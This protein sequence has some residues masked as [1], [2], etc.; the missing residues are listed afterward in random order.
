MQ[1]VRG[2]YVIFADADGA[3]K[4]DDLGKLMDE[5]KTIERVELG[6]AIGSRAHM[7]KSAAVVQVFLST[8]LVLISKRSFIRNL[9]MHG[10][11]AFLRFIGIRSIKDTQCGFKL[12]TRRACAFIFPS[13]HVERW[14]FDVECL[15]LAESQGIPMVEVPVTWH[16]VLSC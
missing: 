4:F 15:Y 16:E 14:A 8:R 12:F 11:H 5:L 10:F 2:R 13:M 7:V 9:T 6:V 1:H 3:S